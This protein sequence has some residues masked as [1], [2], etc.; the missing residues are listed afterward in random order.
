MTN[1]LIDAYGAYHVLHTHLE[2]NLMPSYRLCQSKIQTQCTKFWKR[3]YVNPHNRTH[4]NP[5]VACLH[6]TCMFHI[7]S[8]L[9]FFLLQLIS[10]IKS[11]ATLILWYRNASTTSTFN[12]TT[13]VI[14]MQCDPC[15]PMG[16]SVH[17]RNYISARSIST[18]NTCL[19]RKV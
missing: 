7:L 8:I 12:V 5:E 13:L 3:Q 17:T 11:R 4:S 19:K 9:Q 15:K 6:I 18:F 14:Y 16:L 2:W 10:R 1:R